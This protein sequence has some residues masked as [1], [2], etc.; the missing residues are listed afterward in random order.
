[1]SE[2]IKPRV[3]HELAANSESFSETGSGSDSSSD[4]SSDSDSQLHLARPIFL[5]KRQNIKNETSRDSPN[6]ALAKAEHILKIAAKSVENLPFDGVDDRDD[7][8]PEEEYRQWTLREAARKKRDFDRLAEEEK[9]KEDALRR[10]KGVVAN[11]ESEIHLGEKAKKSVKIGSF[12]AKDVHEKFLKRDY[13]DVEGNE[14]HSRPT[15]YKS[16]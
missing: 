3:E 16:K 10:K 11:P 13:T 8:D 9:A 7:I 12:Y 4:S 15:K 2:I 14:D 1:M 5:K 6:A